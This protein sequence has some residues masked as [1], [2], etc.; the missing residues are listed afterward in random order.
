MGDTNPNSWMVYNGKPYSNGWYRGI[1]ILGHLHMVIYGDWQ[2]PNMG[3]WGKLKDKRGFE[4]T[5]S[6]I[7]LTLWHAMKLS[8]LEPL[9]WAQLNQQPDHD[10]GIRWEPTV[11]GTG[12]AQNWSMLQCLVSMPNCRIVT[13]GCSI[14]DLRQANHANQVAPDTFIC[15]RCLGICFWRLIPGSTIFKMWQAGILESGP[16]CQCG[17]FFSG[18]RNPQCGANNIKWIWPHNT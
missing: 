12:S 15:F 1:P 6:K 2:P 10:S 8:L 16:W 18:T 13:C 17:Q 3:S 11:R 7:W 4:Q 9:I 5:W 14:F